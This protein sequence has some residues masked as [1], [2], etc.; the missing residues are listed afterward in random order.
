MTFLKI[1]TTDA[2]ARPGVDN[3]ETRSELLSPV[4]SG[5]IK[6]GATCALY[7]FCGGLGKPKI[8]TP[9]FSAL[10]KPVSKVICIIMF[11]T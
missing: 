6:L 3:G 1:Q 4:F 2:P 10:T 9:A 11:C 5:S 8:E 7:R